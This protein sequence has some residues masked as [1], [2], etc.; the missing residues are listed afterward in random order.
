MG[1]RATLA[2]FGVALA[3]LVA[4]PASS[5]AQTGD[6][7]EGF[8]TT[9]VGS[10]F[11]FSVEG[12][13]TGANPTGQ[14][15]LTGPPNVYSWEATPRCMNVAGD[16]ATLGFFIES[17]SIGGLDVS[18]QGVLLWV[19]THTEH[20]IAYYKILGRDVPGDPQPI[21]CADPR[22][23]PDPTFSVIG[24][25]GNIDV[26]DKQPPI[27]PGNDSVAGNA[28]AC[29]FI[30]P[31]PE[32]PCGRDLVMTAGAVSDPGGANPGGAVRV[33][34]FGPSPGSIS[35]VEA[36]VT[37]LSV[38]DRVSII[39]V[40]GSRQRGG[41]ASPH[42][43]VAGLIRI[44]DAGGPDSGADTFEFALQEGPRDGPPGPGPTSCSRFPGPFPT[45]PAAI[46]S[47]TNEDGNVAV[48]DAQPTTYTQ[49]RQ[50]GWVKYGFASRAACIDY[51]HDLARRKCTFE[52]VAHGITAFRAKYGLPPNQHH[53]MRH[54]V[55]L[56]TGW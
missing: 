36:A 26:F 25:F 54:C 46:P 45:D 27:P 1:T 49:C 12:T 16:R 4:Q 7:V 5:V 20:G 41:S 39:G 32:E 43:Q 19:Q 24:F 33:D 53:A 13:T 21:T 56:Y 28:H 47:F 15:R 50:A 8:G 18:G 34:D 29:V 11:D 48:T 2:I 42:T 22:P 6:L 31:F 51:V 35:H 10:N 9:D 17:G 23:G 55:R 14:F 30:T 38:S 37:C 44:V 52:R 40:T 3:A